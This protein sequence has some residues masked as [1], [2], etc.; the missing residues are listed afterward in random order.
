MSVKYVV[1]NEHTL[2]YIQEGSSLMGVF[3]G[4]PVSIFEVDSVRPATEAD[5][6][7]FRVAVPPD[8]L[9]QDHQEQSK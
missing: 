5:F 3:G 8:F 7:K 2:G 4:C 1:K 6:H 9:S